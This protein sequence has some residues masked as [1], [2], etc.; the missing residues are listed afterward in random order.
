MPPFPPQNNAPV[1]PA[2]VPSN[3]SQNSGQNFSVDLLQK[4]PKFIETIKTFVIYGTIMA[5]ISSVVGMLVSVFHFSAYSDY[6]SFDFAALIFSIIYGAIGS[7]I[8][9]VVFYFLYEPIKN[10]VKGSG[11]LSKYIHDMFTLFWKP[12]LVGYIISGVFALL[13]ILSIGATLG[14]AA[15]LV[16]VGFGALFVG[17]AVSFVVNIGVYYWYAKA[18]SAKLEPLYPW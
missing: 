18:V 7:A 8:G 4:N 16:A 1:P 10:W 2:P 5:V 6:S 11:F 14:A 12:A 3:P 15:G 17:W 13:S 9:G